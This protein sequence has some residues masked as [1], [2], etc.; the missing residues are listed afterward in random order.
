MENVTIRLS[1]AELKK[2]D[3]YV[4]ALKERSF[5]VEIKQATVIRNLI[6]RGIDAFIIGEHKERATNEQ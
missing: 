3:D 5:G 6:V 1:H 4:K 2:I